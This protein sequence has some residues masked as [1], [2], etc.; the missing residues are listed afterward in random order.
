MHQFSAQKV[1]GQGYGHSY[2][3][4]GYGHSYAGLTWQPHCMLYVDS[5]P[6]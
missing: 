4:Q 1:K 3:G 5:E 6:T 2:A